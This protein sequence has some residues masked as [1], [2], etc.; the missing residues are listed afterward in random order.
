MVGWANTFVYCW[1]NVKTTSWMDGL[2]M[3]QTKPVVCKISSLFLNHDVRVQQVKVKWRLTSI[4]TNN[5]NAGWNDFI[6]FGVTSGVW[7]LKYK[8]AKTPADLDREAGGPDNLFFELKSQ[9]SLTVHKCVSRMANKPICSRPLG[10]ELKLRL[11]VDSLEKRQDRHHD[12]SPW[13]LLGVTK[14][15]SP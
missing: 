7:N 13:W 9:R 12:E 3:K 2:D 6:P 4:M 1:D 11:A 5:P 8:F 14:F 15:V 10:V